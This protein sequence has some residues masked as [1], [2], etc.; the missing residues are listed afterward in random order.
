M[1]NQEQNGLQL[2]VGK[3]LTFHAPSGHVFTIREQNADDDETISEIDP[4]NKSESIK[5]LNTLLSK[6]IIDNS[7]NGKKYLTADEVELLKLKDK[8]YILLKTRLHSIGKDLKFVYKCPNKECKK[9]INFKEDL[10]KYDTDLSKYDA[11]APKYKYQITPY[12]NGKELFYD[13]T[14]SSGKKVRYFNFNVKEEFKLS[15][16]TK[17]S[18]NTELYARGIQLF[19]SSTGLYET[20][21]ALNVFSK[22]DSIEINK[23]IEENDSQFEMFMEMKCPHCKH[24]WKS[25]FLYLK[26]FFFPGE[27]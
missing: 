24:E 27:I 5:N 20:L 23:H 7:V 10:G 14:L 12:R 15:K 1:K 16:L 13:L 22:P 9:E 17:I 11:E 4:E 8:Y 6:I 26:D 3:Q 18:N 19:N 21:G 25:P 2:Y